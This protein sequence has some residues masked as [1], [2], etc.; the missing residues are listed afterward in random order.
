MNYTT[1][2]ALKSVG[3]YKQPAHENQNV[4]CNV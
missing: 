3:C 4:V 1:S 2:N